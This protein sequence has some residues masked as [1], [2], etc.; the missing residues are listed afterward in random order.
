MIDQNLIEKHLKWIEDECGIGRLT[1]N[2]AVLALYGDNNRPG[3]F[4]EKDTVAL[5]VTT[6]HIGV[7]RSR[8]FSQPRMAIDLSSITKI[9]GNIDKLEIKLESPSVPNLPEL[10]VRFTTRAD[11]NQFKDKLIDARDTFS[12]VKQYQALL[13]KLDASISQ[14]C[15]LLEKV[16]ASNRKHPSI[17]FLRFVFAIEKSDRIEAVNQLTRNL[18]KWIAAAESQPI[19]FAEIVANLRF[20]QPET[21]EFLAAHKI[22]AKTNDLWKSAVAAVLLLRQGDFVEGA[23][24]ANCARNQLRSQRTN[25]NTTGISDSDKWSDLIYRLVSPFLDE[26]GMQQTALQW[27]KP[28]ENDLGISLKAKQLEPI[29][30]AQMEKD[31]V[32]MLIGYCQSTFVINRCHQA[33]SQLR[34]NNEAACK[35]SLQSS[36]LAYWK[37]IKAI[38]PY[39][40]PRYLQS[41]LMI[42]E[43]HL[44]AG[45]FGLAKC[46]MEEA[47]QNTLVLSSKSTD[48]L[49]QNV[50]VLSRLYFGIAEK[51]FEKAS[52]YAR[53][54]PAKIDWANQLCTILPAQSTSSLAPLGTTEDNLR[55]FLSWIKGIS[56][57]RP[58]NIPN[59]IVDEIKEFEEAIDEDRIRVIVGGETSAGK[60]TFVNRL[61]EHQI[62]IS[63][64]QEA[65]AVPTHLS[66]ATNWHVR[67][68]FADGNEPVE[69]DFGNGIDCPPEI[70]GMIRYY[71]FLGSES[72]EAVSQIEV[73]GP[74]EVL[75]SGIELIDSPGL[76]A[77]SLRTTIAAR[78]LEKSH[79]CLFVMDARN[80]L[81]GGEMEAIE[82]NQDILGR[83]IFV[84][85]KADLVD[86]GS[87]FDV[88]ENPLEEVAQYVREQ[89]DS[90]RSKSGRRQ[91]RTEVYCVSSINTKA[92][93]AQFENLRLRLQESVQTGKQELLLYRARRLARQVASDSIQSAMNQVRSCELQIATTRVRLPENPKSI[94]QNLQP[95]VKALWESQGSRYLE[96]VRSTISSSLCDVRLE[97]KN[98]MENGSGLDSIKQFIKSNLANVIRKAI[99]RVSSVRNQQWEHLT[100]LMFEDIKGYFRSLY[101]DIDFAYEVDMDDLL[102][103]ATPMPLPSFNGLFADIDQKVAGIGGEATGGATLGAVFGGI[104][105]GPVGAALGGAIGGV[106]GAATASDQ[107]KAEIIKM[108]NE[109]IDSL[110]ELLNSAIDSDLKAQN[111]QQPKILR[112][113]LSCIEREAERF[114]NKVQFK[115]DETRREMQVFETQSASHERIATRAES[116]RMTFAQAC[117]SSDRHTH[118]PLCSL[119]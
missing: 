3:I 41:A 100:Q 82:V 115:I 49:F 111:E 29:T 39:R 104:V 54:L 80:A 69:K 22:S 28:S 10:R 46:V 18:C 4:D 47:Y 108:V 24:F 32:P 77:H 42:A 76:N 23:K 92:Y 27:A 88:G 16:E 58:S 114:A 110:E 59:P 70:K 2:Y 72:S 105:A 35:A 97:M 106:L 90:K 40:D 109:R 21:I 87:E 119:T 44:R 45:E 78:A 99:E 6:T 68:S 9:E 84:L 75:R 93:E 8:W 20:T 112:V 25:S 79:L 101:A 64:R 56:Q 38:T 55:D 91:R 74:I 66:Y 60:S 34:S 30:V 89:L 43:L 31:W 67:V 102:R 51:D 1:V 5:C 116:W 19:G 73:F 65:T 13:D 26:A 71:G 83:T 113:L 17:G 15:E 63:D 12:G 103:S 33:W 53:Q 14:R 85:N 118:E 98:G 86:S 36:P 50:P 37:C 95:R 7:Y 61:V 48:I 94:Q 52:V 57:T 96:S 81:K 117:D 11:Y 107:V 62:L